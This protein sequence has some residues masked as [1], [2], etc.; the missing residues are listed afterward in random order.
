IFIVKQFEIV[1]ARG[2]FANN[3]NRLQ[4]AA[5][6]RV[7]EAAEAHRTILVRCDAH[8]IYPPGYVMKVADA[9]RKSD[10]A[11]LVVPMD[12]VGVGCFQKANAWI[13]NTPLGSGGSAHRGGC[14]SGPVDHGHHAGFDLSWFKN[15]GGYDEAFSHNEDAEYDRRVTSRGGVVFLDADIRVTYSPRATVRALA[16][17]YYKYG[18]GRAATVRKHRMRPKLRQIAPALHVVFLVA[19]LILAVVTPLALVYPVFYVSVLIVASIQLAVS[20]RSVCGLLGG[21]AAATMH[22]AWGTGFLLGLLRRSKSG[23][24]PLAVGTDKLNSLAD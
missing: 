15:V 12:S 10:A 6:N 13:V 19:S 20:R 24:R 17:Q 8:S 22:L 11:S 16:R 21:I 4:S 5:V 18:Q 2:Q 23:R 3:E 7:A 9:L 14:S 1:K